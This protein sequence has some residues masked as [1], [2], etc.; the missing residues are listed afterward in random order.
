[1]TRGK[2]DQKAKPTRHSQMFY[3][4]IAFHGKRTDLYILEGDPKARRGG[5]TARRILICL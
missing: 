3:G 2:V 5:V 4:A 1:L